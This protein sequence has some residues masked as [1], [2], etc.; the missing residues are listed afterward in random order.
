M[1]GVERQLEIA[2][3]HM[4]EPVRAVAASGREVRSERDRRPGNGRAAFVDDASLDGR[5]AGGGR[6]R[7]A[8]PYHDE[9]AGPVLDANRL[10]GG[11]KWR[12]AA[13]IDSESEPA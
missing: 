2:G 9:Q 7:E 12:Q 11:L 10:D 4:G 3:G 1:R 6:S 5:A 13:V 8:A